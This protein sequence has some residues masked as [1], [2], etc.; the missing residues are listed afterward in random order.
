MKTQKIFIE[1]MTM[2]YFKG[3][4][5]LDID[6]NKL[7]NFISGDN[8][9][10]KT[11]IADCFNWVLFDKDS[12]GRK[13]FNIKTINGDGEPMHNIEHE[14]IVTLNVDGESVM[15][16]KVYKEKYTKPRG[17]KDVV[18]DGH[19][20]VY[21][22]NDV[23]HSAGEYAAKVEKICPEKVF[24]L[25]TSP[26]Y[27][28]GLNWTE[29][30]Q[31][32]IGIAGNVKDD[33]IATQDP[34]FAELLASIGQSKTLDEY[35]REL[36]M[37]K[38]R[39]KD[40]LDSI[41]TRIDEVQRGLPE[42]LAWSE[43]E[44]EISTLAADISRI[45]SGILD[46]SK[47]LEGEN[48]KRIALQ[49]KIN[50]GQTAIS[51]LTNKAKTH[52]DNLRYEHERKVR[53]HDQQV[54]DHEETVRIKEDTLKSLNV[55]IETLRAQRQNKLSE[56]HRIN[57]EKLTFTGDKVCPWCDQDIP[58]AFT[59]NKKSEAENKFNKQKSE[60][61]DA[62]VSDGK[63]IAAEIQEVEL[64]IKTAEGVIIESKNKIA[65]LKSQPISEPNYE[66]EKVRFLDGNNF[67]ALTNQIN[68]L[69][70]EFN[71]L[72]PVN[73][74]DTSHLQA[75]K[76][77]KQKNLDN[78][79]WSLTKRDQIATGKKRITE[80]T[81]E[82]QRL[83]Q[84]FADLERIEFTIAKF[85]KAKIEAVEKMVNGMFRI[86]KFKMFNIQV[87]GGIAETC[88]CTVEGVP[89]SDLNTA[90]RINAGIDILSTLSEKYGISAPIFIDNRETINNL[91][92]VASQVINLVVTKDKELV[93][94]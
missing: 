89:Y 54:R 85:S 7:E 73:V 49:S 37:K 69:E 83:S 53:N 17:Q 1:K 31:L 10:G 39:I 11:T 21:Y 76:T 3:I 9:T 57:D 15:L 4:K 55:R 94:N 40:D 92:P 47:G 71:I 78:L 81:E 93:F 58:E 5:H 29:Q 24:K 6:F 48:K 68:N 64:S 42:P 34:A 43:I 90:M 18:F 27:F 8:A 75:Q 56:W 38:K 28:T 52:V 72:G 25:L 84:S 82:Q 80:L 62:N 35:K 63:R 70:E 41:P 50:E 20:T 22:F 23:P 32:L 44:S 79:K 59:A 45:E 36:A 16:R 60:R 51:G 61:L 19:T 66:A 77:E 65:E 2:N 88:E 13:D 87:N 86:V 33:D 30:R 14:S 26:L 12:Y 67:K 74:A 46:A 91:L